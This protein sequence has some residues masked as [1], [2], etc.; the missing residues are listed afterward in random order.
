MKTSYYAITPD[1]TPS[2]ISI[3][4]YPPANT[5]YLHYPA[6]CPSHFTPLLDGSDRR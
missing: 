3:S 2:A 6:L 5:N 4:L 1:T